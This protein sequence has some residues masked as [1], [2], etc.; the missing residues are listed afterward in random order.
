MI[1]LGLLLLMLGAEPAPLVPTAVTASS[2]RAGTDPKMLVDGKLD[3]AWQADASG[4]FG[5]GQWVR[6]DFGKVVD[7][8]RIEIDN[9]VQRVVGDS[10][11]FCMQWRP[12]FFDGYGDTTRIASIDDA[13]GDGRHFGATVGQGLLTPL[14]TRYLTLVIDA[15]E[16]GF[17]KDGA[18]AI[19]EIKVWGQDAP[20]PAAESGPVAC[21]SQR[22]GLLR[23]AVVEHCAATY[24]ATRPTAECQTMRAQFDF[25]KAEPP[26]WMPIAAQA[27]DSGA[28]DLSFKTD[29]PPFPQL[30]AKF[31]RDASGRWTVASLTCMRGKKACGLKHTIASDGDRTD[32]ELRQ[33]KF[34][35]TAAGKFMK[36]P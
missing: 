13:V 26:K 17:A 35:K 8:T 23:Q 7:I 5:I 22:M 29:D 15:V 10:D 16:M 34:C 27:F 9:G 32:L 2:Q 25:C 28:I 24:K 20:Q 33:S 12:M 14:R 19:S 1:A 4:A 11:E 36:A 6:L 21:N 31:T 3:T 18:P 30:G